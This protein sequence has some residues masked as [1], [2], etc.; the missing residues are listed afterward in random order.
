VIAVNAAIIPG[1]VFSRRWHPTSTG[2][3]PAPAA[4]PAS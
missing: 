4:G 1:L 3:P 2:T